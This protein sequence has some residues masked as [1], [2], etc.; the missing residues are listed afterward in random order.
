MRR[1][2]KSFAQVLEEYVKLHDIS[3]LFLVDALRYLFIFSSIIFLILQK[4]LFTKKMKRNLNEILPGCSCGRSDYPESRRRLRGWWQRWEPQFTSVISVPKIPMAWA[5]F[6]W[7]K[8]NSMIFFGLQVPMICVLY[9]KKIPP[10]SS[11]V[12]TRVV[13]LVLTE[14]PLFRYVWNVCWNIQD[15]RFNNA[16][17]HEV[18]KEKWIP[19]QS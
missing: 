19:I 12:R 2:C 6:G 4:T 7:N 9:H 3:N 14:I 13:N 17:T 15:L 11:V 18:L 16:I 5:V 1:D 10:I 8:S